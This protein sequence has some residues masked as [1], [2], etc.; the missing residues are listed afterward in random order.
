MYGA[1]MFSQETYKAAQYVSTAIASV[2]E[3]HIK[4][5]GD[6]KTIRIDADVKP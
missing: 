6:A 2:D 1:E 3:V 4:V 5:Q